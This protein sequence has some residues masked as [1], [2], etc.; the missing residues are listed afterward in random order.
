M[1]SSLK[2]R[3]FRIYWFGMFVSLIG[4]WIQATAQSWLVFQLTDSAFL[5]G[6]TGFLSYIP[7]FLFSLFAGLLADRFN[8]KNILIFTQSVFMLLAFLL[9]VLTQLKLIT[10]AQVML[11]AFLNGVVMAFDAPSRQAMVVEL[12]GKEKLFNAVALSSLAF[13]SSRV[14]GP[15]LAGMLVAVIGMS[16]CF[17]VN[18]VSFLAIIIALFLIRLDNNAKVVKNKKLFEDLKEGLIFIKSHQ[19]ILALIIMVGVVSLFG[20][21]YVMLMPVFAKEVLKVGFKGLGFLMSCIGIGALIGGLL[22]ARLGNFQYKGRLLIITALIFSVSLVL[23]S[24]SKNYLLSLF[25]LAISGGASVMAISIIN[26]VLQTESSDEF[27]GR[28]MSVFMLTFA[29]IMPFGNLIAGSLAS[30]VGVSWTLLINGAICTA[31]FFI[32]NLL[33]PQIRNIR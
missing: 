9:A 5:L 24:I 17:Y 29:G 20:T 11:I 26:I 23:F 18:G 10:A 3:N 33:Y 13:N 15:S 4:T 14:L 12:A 6:L 31:L 28:V 8:K 27:R 1:F 32:I 21:S 30:I 19:L 25:I 16:G 22:L 2:V 7:V